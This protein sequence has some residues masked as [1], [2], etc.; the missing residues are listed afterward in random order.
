MLH[1]VSLGLV[2]FVV[3]LLLSGH[4]EPLLLG[5]G[6]VS[7]VLVG[8]IAHR[9]DL[10]DHEGQPVHLG[11]RVVPYWL[12]L[13]GEIVKS[14]IAVAKVIL[15]PGLP[16]SPVMVRPKATQRSEL[17]RVIFANSITLTPGTVSVQVGN[18]AILVHAVTEEIG[19]DLMSG[20]MDGK[21]SAMETLPREAAAQS[22]KEPA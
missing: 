15:D 1:Y 13:L 2:L 16:I 17:G 19:A 10:V 18:D 21:V 22:G 7:C 4:F 3:W 12:W 20:T 5:F 6:L 9:M 8:W 14:N 11:W